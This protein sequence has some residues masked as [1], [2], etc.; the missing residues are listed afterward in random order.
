MTP[1]P[2]PHTHQADPSLLMVT[3]LAMQKLCL[4]FDKRLLPML[5]W[6]PSGI[7]PR[8]NSLVRSTIGAYGMSNMALPGGTALE[9]CTVGLFDEID[10]LDAEVDR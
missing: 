3:N 4:S 1:I 8:F 2:P 7:G 5:S 10:K 6:A 9:D